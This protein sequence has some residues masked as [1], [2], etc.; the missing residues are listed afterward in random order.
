MGFYWNRHRNILEI[1]V[2]VD[3]CIYCINLA[4]MK[5]FPLLMWCL[6][7]VLVLMGS[8]KRYTQRWTQPFLLLQNQRKLIENKTNSSVNLLFS[9]SFTHYSAFIFDNLLLNSSFYGVW[10]WSNTCVIMMC[11][12]ILRRTFF[13][14]QPYNQRTQTAEEHD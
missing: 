7:D 5:S 9:S 13:S 10:F 1:M 2:P 12:R 6:V 3:L 4:K 11:W 14:S 8:E